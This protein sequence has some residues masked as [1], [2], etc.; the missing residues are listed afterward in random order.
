MSFSNHLKEM[1]DE[2]LGFLGISGTLLSAVLIGILSIAIY[3][4]FFLVDKDYVRPARDP[5]LPPATEVVAL[6]IH[7]I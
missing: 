2:M 1:S 6:R 3:V 4:N 7:P 5:N